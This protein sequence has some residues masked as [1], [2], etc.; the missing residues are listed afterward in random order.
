MLEKFLA[1]NDKGYESVELSEVIETV[2]ASMNEREKSFFDKR[3]LQNKT[4][5]EIAEELGV[6]QMTISRIEK[7]IRKKFAEELHK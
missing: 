7:E 4:Q 3:Y 1:V 6:S 5:A 2:I